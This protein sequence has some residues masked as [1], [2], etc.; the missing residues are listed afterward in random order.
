M[1]Q[2]RYL[3]LVHFEVFYNSMLINTGFSEVYS[4]NESDAIK[5]CLDRNPDDDEYTIQISSVERTDILDL[6]K[7]GWE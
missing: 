5:Q 1:R 2:P 6:N 4:T 7:K 3:Y